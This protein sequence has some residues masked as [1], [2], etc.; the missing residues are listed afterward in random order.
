M[1]RASLKT[2]L[3]V[4]VGKGVEEGGNTADSLTINHPVDNRQ[5]KG[6][7]DFF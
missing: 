6:I 5:D 1:P 7:P 3:D 2:M 4:I